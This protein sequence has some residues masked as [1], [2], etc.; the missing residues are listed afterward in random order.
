M[1]KI[2]IR[3]IYTYMKKNM[4]KHFKLYIC[5]QLTKKRTTYCECLLENE[6]LIELVY[7][8]V[9]YQLKAEDV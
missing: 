9:R 6:G 5:I 7:V 3:F 8:R 1:Y 4:G 2:T